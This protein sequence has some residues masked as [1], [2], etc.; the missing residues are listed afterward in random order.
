MSKR[1]KPFWAPQAETTKAPLKVMVAVFTGT[2]RNGWVHPRLTT[3]ILRIAFDPRI[4]INYLPVHAIYPVDAARNT[5]VDYFLKSNSDLL[6][7]FDNDVAPPI[8]V[9]EAVASFPEQAD[10]GVLP[11]WVW[12]P[13]D[14]HTMPCFGRWENGE[15]VI[16][17]PS[18]LLPGW[19]E[20][21]VGGTG[22]MF[23]R[24]KVFESGKLEKPFFKIVKHETL[25]QSVSEDIYFT[26]LAAE[27]GMKTWVNTDY[28]CSH[29]HTIDLSE[30][31]E[32]TVRILNRFVD[33]IKQ[34]YGDDSIRIEDL[35]EKVQP[36]LASAQ[37]ARAETIAAGGN[38][39]PQRIPSLALSEWKKA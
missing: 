31:N 3:A 32:G 7:L 38:P 22:A 27:T 26:G 1:N 17:D 28:I 4:Q 36:E 19:Q 15:M 16:P 13:E 8:D 18:T 29:F 37:K 9:V 35:I 24:R 33:A 20:M 30:V 2:E 23:I 34:K 21:G 25:A 11:Y 39:D 5:C 6:V 12:L 14:K 10:I